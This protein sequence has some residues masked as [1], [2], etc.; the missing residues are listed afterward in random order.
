MFDKIIKIIKFEKILSNNDIENEVLIKSIK[1][2]DSQLKEFHFYRKQKEN[3]D[4]KIAL[5]LIC[6]QTG[7]HK[8]LR[9]RRM[10]ELIEEDKNYQ[11]GNEYISNPE[12]KKTII[13]FRIADILKESKLEDLYLNIID[14]DDIVV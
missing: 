7:L 1:S 3:N 4:I 6:F 2:F 9:M 14:F 11:S 13:N 10:I 12:T 5:I 8:L